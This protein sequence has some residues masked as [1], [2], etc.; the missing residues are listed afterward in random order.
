MRRVTGRKFTCVVAMALLSGACSPPASEVSHPFYVM[1]MPDSQERA[2][3]RCPDGPRK[4]CAVDGLP[5]PD[6]FAANGDRRH[7][8][9]ARRRGE[10]V[11]YLYFE[12]I[13]EELQGWG[14]NPEQV[15]GPLNRREFEADAAR[16]GLPEP[17]DVPR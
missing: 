12:R 4:G 9:V 10:V 1:R 7:I 16:L 13:P 6:V 17:I 14:R 2:L 15:I 11:E 5:G 3:Y 8:V